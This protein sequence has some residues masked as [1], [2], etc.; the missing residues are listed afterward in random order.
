MRK[1]VWYR[2]LGVKGVAEGFKKRTAKEVLSP[3]QKKMEDFFKRKLKV[4]QTGLS[5]VSS[6]TKTAQGAKT[7]P[8]EGVLGYL[9]SSRNIKKEHRPLT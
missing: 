8:L 1:E 2:Y 6:D 5:R 7:S 3:R 4:G 9:C